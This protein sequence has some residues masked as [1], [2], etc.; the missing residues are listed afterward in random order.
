[1]KGRYDMDD[2]EFDAMWRA[3][4]ADE[5]RVQAPGRL[6][7]A[8]MAAWDAAHAQ[9]LGVRPPRRRRVPV[10]VLLAAAA[11][12][13]A[14]GLA[15]RY[16]GER[17]VGSEVGSEGASEGGSE[18][19]AIGQVAMPAEPARAPA[20]APDTSPDALQESLPERLSPPVGRATRRGRTVTSATLSR[21]ADAGPIVA[22]PIVT[23]A[24][25]R[26]FETEVR[27]IIRVRVPQEALQAFG[28]P[29]PDPEASH[30]VD[31]DVLVGD[32]GLARDIRRIRPVADTGTRDYN[33]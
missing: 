27:H 6:G 18:A 28:V 13:L 32:D 16:G 11:L 3:F 9:P 33:R 12:V 19:A 7:P 22:G 8:V 30:L 26:A 31:V 15:V 2:P 23:L 14:A 25:D 5:A 29:L 17:E 10:V 24:A 20:A 21:A 1:V 4:A